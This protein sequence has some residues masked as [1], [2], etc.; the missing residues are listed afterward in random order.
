M[1]YGMHSLPG[2]LHSLVYLASSGVEEG[3]RERE[4]KR[5]IIEE[6]GRQR[7]R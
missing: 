5:E 2:R 1:F 7:E 4:K 6:S 3:E